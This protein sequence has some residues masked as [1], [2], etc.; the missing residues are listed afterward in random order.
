LAADAG[1]PRLLLLEEDEVRGVLRHRH[2]IAVEVNVLLG[3]VRVAKLREEVDHVLQPLARAGEGDLFVLVGAPGVE[4]GALRPLH[5]AP[6]SSS[7]CP[8]PR[9]SSPGR[10]RAL[11]RL[12]GWSRASAGW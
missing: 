4:P 3:I 7:P 2:D 9:G 12:P 10:W 1:E 8:C 6:A 5:G 11:P